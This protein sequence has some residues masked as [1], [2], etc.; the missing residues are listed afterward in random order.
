[1]WKSLAGILLYANA[2]IPSMARPRLSAEQRSLLA[3]CYCSGM[4]VANAAKTVGCADNTARKYYEILLKEG[5]WQDK[6]LRLNVDYT[7][8]QAAKNILLGTENRQET[9]NKINAL[10]QIFEAAQVWGIEIG[11]KEAKNF[12]NIQKYL[13]TH[14]TNEVKNDEGQG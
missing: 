7:F 3:A 1:M 11:S 8:R 5:A 10:K 13:D 2:V 14:Y 4:T 9:I 6:E 12:G